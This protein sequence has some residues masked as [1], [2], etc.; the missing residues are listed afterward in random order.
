MLE[1]RNI[2]RH[3]GVEF[4][5]SEMTD[6][7]PVIIEFLGI[8]LERQDLDQI[9][10]RRYLLEELLEK[11]FKNLTLELEKR[12]SPYS[13]LI[14]AVLIAMADDM[15]QMAGGPKWRPPPEESQRRDSAADAA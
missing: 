6:F 11:G 2:Y 10:L 8:S 12:E 14:D 1:L 7:V 13:Q 3:F 5:G 9:G 4:S 15:E